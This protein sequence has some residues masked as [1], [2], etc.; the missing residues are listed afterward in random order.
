MMRHYRLDRDVRMLGSSAVDKL[1]SVRS[2]AMKLLT[3]HSSFA[4]WGSCAVAQLRKYFISKIRS[5]GL[6]N[7]AQAGP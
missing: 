5:F 3:S 2:S 1:T 6:E 7:A 4:R